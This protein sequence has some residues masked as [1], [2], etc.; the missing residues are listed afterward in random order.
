M[1]ACEA[2]ELDGGVNRKSMIGAL[3]R[4]SRTNIARVRAC[5]FAT[6]RGATA[7]CMQRE[8]G[9]VRQWKFVNWFS[10]EATRKNKENRIVN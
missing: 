6:L 10:L 5:A 1:R 9:V 2:V 3:T 7:V 8:L 4:L